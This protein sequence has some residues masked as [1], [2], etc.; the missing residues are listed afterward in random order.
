MS[1]SYVR[2]VIVGLTVVGLLG[3]PGAATASAP[4]K[5]TAD[6]RVCTPW[7]G[8]GPPV[9]DPRPLPRLRPHPGFGTTT[10]IRGQVIANVG[11]GSGSV[12]GATVKLYRKAERQQHLGV[13]RLGG[14]V[15]P[16]HA[17]RS[18]TSG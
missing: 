17:R 13:R 7:H 2:A 8:A 3:L 11:A 14:D 15:V 16:E 18:S 10:A 9:R 4:T 5:G 6:H 1:K 12:P